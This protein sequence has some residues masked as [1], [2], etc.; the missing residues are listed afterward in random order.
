[1]RNSSSYK[2]KINFIRHGKTP[3]NDR[4]LYISRTDESLSES[5]K[6][7]L[8]K[9]NYPDC[10][11][12][13]TSGYK[14]CNETA[15]TIYKKN[16]IIEIPDFAELDFGDFEGKGYEDLKDNP[17]YQKWI[18]GRGLMAMPNG[19]SRDAFVKRLCKGFESVLKQSKGAEEISLVVHGGTIMGLVS[20]Y[21]DLDYYEVQLK[22]GE[23]LS[24]TID[25][26]D[27]DGV[28]FISRFRIVDRSGS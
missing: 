15:E 19:E 24:C 5:G 9:H 16:G 11:L 23:C 22:C 27:L 28:I 8:L 26:E 4:H 25:F 17:E 2:I 6:S 20:N 3:S 13:F 18:E 21:T 1:M 12:L 7:E 14:R 10:D